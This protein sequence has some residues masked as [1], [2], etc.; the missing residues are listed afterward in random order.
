MAREFDR[1]NRNNR[2]VG[3]ANCRD[4]IALIAPE[5]AA[6]TVLNQSPGNEQGRSN[7]F[8]RYGNIGASGPKRD[9][10]AVTEMRVQ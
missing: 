7:I 8:Q 5:P 4:A 10:Y 1:T 2:K 3:L 6:C 9:H